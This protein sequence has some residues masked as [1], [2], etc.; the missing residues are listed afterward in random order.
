MTKNAYTGDVPVA[1]ADGTTRTMRFDFEALA[2]CRTE[3]GDE[4]AL[5]IVFGGDVRAL[6][7]LALIGFRRHHPEMT[8]AELQDIFPPVVP[9]Q[10][11][12]EQALSFA[13]FGPDGPPAES[14]E[15]NP[16]NRAAR[17][18]LARQTTKTR[19]T[20]SRAR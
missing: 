10:R 5:K 7:T 2:A 6:A 18:A 3:L 13:Y 17:R 16:P 1:M 14:G 9:L 12:I 20:G 4:Q 19:K 11:A 8:L 15:A